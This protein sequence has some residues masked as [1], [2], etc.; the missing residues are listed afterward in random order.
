MTGSMSTRT[1]KWLSDF[2]AEFYSVSFRLPLEHIQTA[3]AS[4]SEV[5]LRPLSQHALQH[6]GSVNLRYASETFLGHGWFIDMEF[7]AASSVRVAELYEAGDV[8]RADNL[9]VEYY[10][11]RLDAIQQTL[12]ACYEDRA[13]V[14]QK[15]FALHREGEYDVSVPLFLIQADGIC[16]TAFGREF[17]RAKSGALAVHKQLANME[18]DWIWDAM[19]QPFRVVPPIA[20]PSRRNT[21][22]NRHRILHGVSLDYGSEANSLR[23]VSL[24]AFLQGLH[25]YAERAATERPMVAPSV[26]I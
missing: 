3:L 5:E 17:F 7:P 21:S 16:A 12:V 4:L 22:Y 20:A 8:S 10:K 2:V 25:E 26:R 19:L 6:A 1:Q 11:R 14:L 15:A 23:A 9:L 18:V 13:S 24:L